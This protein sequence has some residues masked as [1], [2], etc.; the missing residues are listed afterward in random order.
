[1]IIEPENEESKDD[2][3]TH[4]ATEQT[5]ESIDLFQPAMLSDTVAVPDPKKKPNL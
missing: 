5:A 4:E 1:M 3:A 2:E